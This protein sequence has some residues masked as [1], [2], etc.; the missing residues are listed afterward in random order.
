LE[1][2]VARTGFSRFPV[3][4]AAG[5]LVGYLHVM[6]VLDAAGAERTEPVPHRRI[7]ALSQASPDNEVEDVLAIMQRSGTHLARVGQ[8]DATTGVVFL[9]D[10]IEELVGEVRDAMQR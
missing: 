10:I 9:E 2:E 3:A 8:G 6:D 7:R 5:R 1:R 4:D